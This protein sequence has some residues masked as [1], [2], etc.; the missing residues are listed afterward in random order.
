VVTALGSSPHKRPAA[1]GA[2]W[3]ELV[4]S[5]ITDGERNAKITRITGLLLHPPLEGVDAQVVLE[6]MQCLNQVRCSPPL[7]KD[8]VTAI[9][10]SIAGRELA[11]REKHEEGFSDE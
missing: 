1:T 11:R 10:N 9:V 5:A 8:E 7:G 6:L 4:C 2:E 3:H